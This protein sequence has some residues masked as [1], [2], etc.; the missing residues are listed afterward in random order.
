M[1]YNFTQVFPVPMQY[2]PI[3]VGGLRLILDNS[4]ANSR[5]GMGLFGYIT[6][7][8]DVLLHVVKAV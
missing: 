5:R 8:T 1:M 2:I 3:T 6:H 4:S 7:R